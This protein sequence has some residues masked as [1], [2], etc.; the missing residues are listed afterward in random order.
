MNK[1]VLNQIIE[2]TVDGIMSEAYQKISNNA[3]TYEL[4][5]FDFRGNI[6][7]LKAP[8]KLTKSEYGEFVALSNDE[9]ELYGTGK[10]EQEALEMIRGL[11]SKRYEEA[12]KIM[13]MG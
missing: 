2:K 11:F 1:S 12:K 13:E 9:F 4:K 6:I 10:N 7:E 8:L 3:C 5:D